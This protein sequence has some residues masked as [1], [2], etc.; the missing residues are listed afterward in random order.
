MIRLKNYNKY[1]NIKIKNALGI[2][3]SK[4]EYNA[5]LFLKNLEK[6]GFIKDLKRQVGIILTPNKEKYKIK[7]VADFTYFDTK[8][9]MLTI[10]DSK[11]IQTKE[12]KIK[13]EW[14]LHWFNGFIF[15][16]FYKDK[17]KHYI[18]YGNNKIILKDTQ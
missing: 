1:R 2:F 18:P 14:L 9:N 6:K 16:E 10:A 15:V 17:T 8:T 7:Y 13:R 12:Y 5:F 3:D 11:G 4:L